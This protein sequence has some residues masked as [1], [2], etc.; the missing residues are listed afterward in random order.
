MKKIILSGIAA[1]TSLVA[2]AQSETTPGILWSATHHVEYAV[3]AG[4]NLGG[5]SPLPLPAEIRKINSYSPNMNLSIAGSAT[6]WLGQHKKWGVQLG[7]S[8]GTRGMETGATVK[9]YSM[10]IIDGGGSLSGYWTGKVQTK[11]SSTIL[12]IPVSAMYK[13][14]N[15]VRFNFGPYVGFH[16]KGDFHGA[17]S[18]GYLRKDTPTGD[19]VEF[20]DGKEATYDFSDELRTFQWGLQ[21][22]A[23]W[24]AFKHLTIHGTLSW[25]MNDIFKS[26]F[27]TITFNMYPIYLNAGFGYAF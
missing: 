16:I 25:G 13:L 26:S 12:M 7:V 24:L 8:L 10:E 23:T 2:S 18:D 21:G 20:T 17:V 1:L 4:I 3:T 11:Y 14:N 6:K 22:G 19:K 15:R 27:K 9:S 5:S